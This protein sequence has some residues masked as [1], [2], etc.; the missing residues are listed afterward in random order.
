MWTI[1]ALGL[2]AA[3]DPELLAVVVVVLTR[4]KP[5]PLLRACYL[6]SL[7]VSVACGI[8]IVAVFNSHGRVA[9]SSS[10]SVSPTAYV[11]VGSIGLLV[12]LFVATRF[13]RER[14]GADQPQQHRRRRRARQKAGPTEHV[15]AKAHEA[16]QRG[17]VPVA[18]A[19][20]VTI[21]LPG[22]LDLVAFGYIARHG[23][24]PVEAGLL[25]LT[26]VV[27]KLL[28][29]DVPILSYAVAPAR[30]ASWVETFSDWMHVHKIELIAAVV[31]VIGL[32]LIA[33]G[34]TSI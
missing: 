8:A 1:V 11:L 27:I 29:M 23:Y 15:K 18:I 34:V 9:G 28:L 24:A 13:G 6:S 21:G 22:A 33:K 14:L 5:K 2:A 10:N 31:G 3:V 17:S 32:V 7:S 20:G 30:T 4:E 16:L 26:F 12:A 19:V 25:I